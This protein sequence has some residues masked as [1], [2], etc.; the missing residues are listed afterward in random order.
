MAQYTPTEPFQSFGGTHLQPRLTGIDRSGLDLMLSK[1]QHAL[2]FSRRS[3]ATTRRGE[4]QD[5]QR[6]RF[7]QLECMWDAMT[8]R[9][10]DLMEDYNDELNAKDTRNLSAIQRFR[11]LGLQSHLFHFILAKL[12]PYY[13]LELILEG[14]TIR[15]YRATLETKAIKEFEQVPWRRVY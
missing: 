15:I 8:W 1:N 11:S 12:N 10:R 2:I 4:I 9:Q 14:P 3:R 6:D 5:R 7:T 13:T